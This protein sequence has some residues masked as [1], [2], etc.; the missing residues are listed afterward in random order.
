[1]TITVPKAKKPTN[2]DAFIQAA[3][4]AAAD[5]AQAP[6]PKRLKA[7]RGTTKSQVSVVLADELVARLDVEAGKA[8]MTRSAYITMALT[9]FLSKA[10]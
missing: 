10:S 8:Y 7:R 1:M 4:D 6:A 3:P 9:Q 5:P 2:P